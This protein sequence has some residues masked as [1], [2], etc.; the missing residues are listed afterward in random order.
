M[1]AA[2]SQEAEGKLRRAC[3]VI[4]PKFS[5]ELNQPPLRS[6]AKKGVERSGVSLIELLSC[7]GNIRGAEKVF[8]AASL[9]LLKNKE[10]KVICLETGGNEERQ[11]YWLEN[12]D[13]FRVSV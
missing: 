6:K 5:N 2:C 10:K 9:C 11:Y 13:M 3:T 1:L 7:G 8:P 4:P 12:G